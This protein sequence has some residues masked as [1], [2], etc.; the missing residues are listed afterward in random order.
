MA[1][2]SMYNRSL[3]MSD[4]NLLILR[5]P[6]NETDETDEDEAVLHQHTSGKSLLSHNTEDEYEESDVELKREDSDSGILRN[7]SL[8]KQGRDH[9]TFADQN[10]SHLVEMLECR[11]STRASAETF[12]NFVPRNL[13]TTTV[14]LIL[15]MEDKFLDHAW[16]CF[17]FVSKSLKESERA[18]S[19]RAM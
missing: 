15:E 18:V 2:A 11:G 4:N 6:S 12:N 5:F 19:R 1:M 10:V 3:Q 16:A 8:A 13:N 7:R 17:S 9:M 14:A